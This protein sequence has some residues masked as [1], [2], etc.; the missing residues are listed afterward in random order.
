MNP[1]KRL[2][3]GLFIL[4]IAIVAFV[5]LDFHIAKSATNTSHNRTRASSSVPENYQPA[6]SLLYIAPAKNDPLSRS[7]AEAVYHQ[8]ASSNYFSPVL[9]ENP[10]KGEQ[11]P[12]LLVAVKE[13][14]FFWTPFFAQSSLK[15]EFAFS[16]FTA[17]S[18]L[19]SEQTLILPAEGAQPAIHSSGDAMQQDRSYGL[20]SLPGYRSLV[21]DMAAKT[22]LAD[23]E[24]EV[25]LK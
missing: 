8:A 12:A 10:P 22:L 1:S 2:R 13:E 15:T 11:Y 5:F 17:V 6:G 7:L 18:D 9:L 25:Q 20:I 4:I 3:I 19:A 14:T 21:I 24:L 23:L 16:N